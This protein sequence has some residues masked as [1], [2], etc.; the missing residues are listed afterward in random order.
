MEIYQIKKPT[1]NRVNRKMTSSYYYS[2]SS[3]SSSSNRLSLA[4]AWPSHP[5]RTQIKILDRVTANSFRSILLEH[6]AKINL[7]L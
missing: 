2:Y 3:P 7:E 5:V 6:Y 4:L 1:Q